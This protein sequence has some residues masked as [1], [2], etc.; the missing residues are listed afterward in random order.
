MVG[1]CV[2][3]ICDWELRWFVGKD[4]VDLLYEDLKVCEY[5]VKCLNDVVVF[6]VEIECVVNCLNVM[7]YIVKFGMVIGKG[8]IEVELFC[9][10]FN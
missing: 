8:G 10:V 1:F 2:G 9:K 7:I 5:I 6:K 4:Y 3:V